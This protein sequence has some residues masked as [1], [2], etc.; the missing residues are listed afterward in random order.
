M[1]AHYDILMDRL[2]FCQERGFQKNYDVGDFGRTRYPDT[3]S[4]MVTKRT[5]CL[6]VGCPRNEQI[7][8][9]ICRFRN[10]LNY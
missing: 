10:I 4:V 9:N 6:S 7:D 5:T 1:Y 8:T 3:H 2:F